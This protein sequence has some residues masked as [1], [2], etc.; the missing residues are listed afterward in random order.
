MV[1]KFD[2]DKVFNKQLDE[3]VGKTEEKILAVTKNSIQEV[4]EEAS[5]PVK[6]GGKMRVDTGFLRSSGTASLNQLPT[7]ESE[8]RKRIAGELGVLPEYSNYNTGS[9]L[10]AVLA[11]FKLGD[12]FYFGWCANYAIYRETYDGFLVSACQNWSSIVD[13]NM[14]RLKK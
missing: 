12:T 5:T 1:G 13:K 2:F 6:L 3:F 9:V 11:D 8:G 4:V 7:G 14:R 10:Q